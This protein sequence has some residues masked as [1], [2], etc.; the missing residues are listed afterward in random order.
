MKSSDL[1]APLPTRK[2]LAVF[3]IESSNCA[4]QLS[5]FKLLSLKFYLQNFNHQIFNP[6]AFCA[7]LFNFKLLKNC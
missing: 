6:R 3:H 1:P 5:I 7:R 2:K 4:L